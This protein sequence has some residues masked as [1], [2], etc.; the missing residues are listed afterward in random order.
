MGREGSGGRLRGGTYRALGFLLHPWASTAWRAL[1]PESWVQQRPGRQRR[2]LAAAGE[3][4]GS[5]ERSAASAAGCGG[6][7]GCAR[8][9]R[10]RDMALPDGARRPT[11]ARPAIALAPPPPRS[12]ANGRGSAP[13]ACSRAAHGTTAGAHKGPSALYWSAPGRDGGDEGRARLP[14]RRQGLARAAA[15]GS[16]TAEP[17]R[18][19][20]NAKSSA[21]RGARRQMAA[22]CG[23][24]G[25]APAAA[26]APRAHAA[27]RGRMACGGTRGPDRR[28][29]LDLRRRSAYAPDRGACLLLRVLLPRRAGQ[30][31]SSTRLLRAVPAARRRRWRARHTARGGMRRA[32]SLALLLRQRRPPSALGRLHRPRLPTAQQAQGTRGTSARA[33]AAS[34]AALTLGQA[35][36][37][38]GAFLCAHPPAAASHR[39][40]RHSNG[41]AHR[42]TRPCEALCA[43]R[44][45]QRGPLAWEHFFGSCSRGRQRFGR[46]CRRLRRCAS[47]L[48]Q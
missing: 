18:S 17:E 14:S 22:G 6:V 1:A 38:L 36:H 3:R 12:L 20:A 9:V 29:R 35:A 34:S 33:V 21:R 16:C 45:H 39:R 44:R 37:A 28:R 13:R 5:G 41:L 24:R 30:Q 23:S 2:R 40:Q 8:R 43:R 48:P 4:L 42:Y 19:I 27:C 26:A 32:S 25:A 10:C 47:A 46:S 15:A 31:Q 7:C 11:T